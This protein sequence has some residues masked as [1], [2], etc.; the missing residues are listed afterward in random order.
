[1]ITEALQNLANSIS[2]RQERK[3][4]LEAEDT[5]F[6]LGSK[7]V[8]EIQG[9]TDTQS[10]ST[11][12]LKANK[13]AYSLG[14]PQLASQINNLGQIK[15]QE[16]I[17]GK[18]DK[19]NLQQASAIKDIYGDQK[20]L[21]NNQYVSLNSLDE[22]KKGESLDPSVQSQ[23]YRSLAD[24]YKTSIVNQL[25][26]SNVKNPMLKVWAERNGER[27]LLKEYHRTKSGFYD[28]LLTKDTIENLPTPPEITEFQSKM[29]EFQYKRQVSLADD[30]MR[31]Y[32]PQLRDIDVEDE[33]G[34]LKRVPVWITPPSKSNPNG[35]FVTPTGEDVT[36]KVVNSRA[37]RPS[38]TAVLKSA[39][40][41]LA[42]KASYSQARDIFFAL[43]NKGHIT[44]DILNT[45]A[46]KSAIDKDQFKTA[47]QQY[48]LGINPRLNVEAFLNSLQENIDTSK[49][50][51]EGL[52]RAGF[53]QV[54]GRKDPEIQDLLDQYYQL[55]GHAKKLSEIKQE[56]DV[57]KITPGGLPAL[58]FGK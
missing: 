22:F 32:K 8:N 36:D 7:F 44:E 3:R 45:L 21:V 29:S 20:V 41:N 51:K 11:A 2:Q 19:I 57:K 13:I 16:L 46:E 40:V 10:L 26:T 48:Q 38:T 55:R 31:Y 14:V 4:T 24:K 12:M 18:T 28:D 5:M 33:S 1:M 9:A 34:N 50:Q 43:T 53:L 58:S 17:Q 15:H 39:D 6:L 23:Y 30:D 56:Q 35:K 47:V 37:Q 25:D 27:V 54:I 49:D 42:R 52:P